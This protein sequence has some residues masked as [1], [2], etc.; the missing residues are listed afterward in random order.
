MAC[1]P[2]YD[3]SGQN[4]VQHHERACLID[5][6]EQGCKS[7]VAKIEDYAHDTYPDVLHT[8]QRN[9]VLKVADYV[10]D[11]QGDCTAAFREET[12]IAGTV[13][14]C[15]EEGN[16]VPFVSMLEDGVW[17]FDPK[18]PI[19]NVE[20]AVAEAR[21]TGLYPLDDDQLAVKSCDSADD[22]DGVLVLEVDPTPGPRSCAW[23][24]GA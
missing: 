21:W 5:L 6:V 20:I 4:C 15:D 9:A 13:P 7:M 8:A 12:G 16:G 18:G 22:N 24:R 17:A 1:C 10:R 23:S 14:E 2:S 11:H 19:D 3:A